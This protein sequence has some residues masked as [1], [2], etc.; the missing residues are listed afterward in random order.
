MASKPIKRNA[1][2]ISKTFAVVS[3]PALHMEGKRP[4]STGHRTGGRRGASGRGGVEAVFDHSTNDGLET[5]SQAAGTMPPAL[6][7]KRPAQT[8][9]RPKTECDI[10]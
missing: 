7:L 2:G 10:A 5:C 8:L 9:G 6:F 4:L 1:Y 3:A